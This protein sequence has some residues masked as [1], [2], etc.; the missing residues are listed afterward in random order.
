MSKALVQVLQKR[1]LNTGE[2]LYLPG[3]PI[4]NYVEPTYHTVG[5]F[6]SYK[7]GEQFGDKGDRWKYY[8]TP[9]KIGPEKPATLNAN[10]DAAAASGVSLLGAA[11]LAA[12]AVLPFAAAAGVGYGAYKLGQSLSLW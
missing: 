6:P 4:R 2:Q 10:Y 3:E 1:S 8:A 5:P 9:R 11:S 12:P 7:N